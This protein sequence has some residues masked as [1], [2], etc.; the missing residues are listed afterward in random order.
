[1]KKVISIG[2]FAL[3]LYHTLAYVLMCVGVWWQAEHDLSERLR[4]YRSV[5]SIVEFQVPLLGEPDASAIRQTTSDGF[6]YRGRYYDVV[7]LDVR[8][9]TLFIAG[10]ESESRSFWQGDLLSFLNDHVASAADSHQK[11]GRLL[12]LLLKEYSPNPQTVFTFASFYR[13]H[14]GRIAWRMVAVANCVLP[15]HCPPPQIG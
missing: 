14:A 15:V 4:V 10:L 9:D 6:A 5:D 2:L 8:S 3:L 12:K 13:H 11:A 1:M 7:S